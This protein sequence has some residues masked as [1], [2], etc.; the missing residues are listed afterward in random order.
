MFCDMPVARS[1]AGQAKATSQAEEKSPPPPIFDPSR[2]A[3]IC[4]THRRGGKIRQ[5]RARDWRQLVR[6]VPRDGAVHPG[7]TPD[8][9]ALIDEHYVT[10]R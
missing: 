8:L 10:V 4:R 2:P 7:R 9:K 6:L 1:V 3:G 5:A